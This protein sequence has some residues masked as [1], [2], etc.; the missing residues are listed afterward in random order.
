M[1]S[2]WGHDPGLCQVIMVTWTQ[3]P[4]LSV[5]RNIDSVPF[6]FH[7]VTYLWE[8]LDIQWNNAWF[9]T[10]EFDLDYTDAHY[11]FLSLMH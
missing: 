6:N 1:H 3:F 2:H 8:K 7:S 9:Y 4:L 10:L 11:T 5:I